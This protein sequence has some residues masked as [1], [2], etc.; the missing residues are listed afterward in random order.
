MTDFF[1]IGIHLLVTSVVRYGLMTDFF[2][3]LNLVN[4]PKSATPPLAYSLAYSHTY[5]LT[6]LLTLNLGPLLTQIDSHSGLTNPSLRQSNQ[7]K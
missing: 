6:H 4:S 7:E 5:S 1:F 2:Y 3:L